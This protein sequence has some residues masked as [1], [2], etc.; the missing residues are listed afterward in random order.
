[1]TLKLW[2]MTAAAGLFAST[3]MADP[4]GHWDGHMMWGGGY[5]VFGGLMMLVFW[6]VVIA[7]IVLAVHWL[8]DSRPGG[9][10]SS[11]A[12]DILR[13]RLAKGEIDEDEFR[14]RKA[15]LEE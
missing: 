15:T 10:R 3:A 8:R 6:G 5:G 13:A 14:R 12:L 9:A 1:M 7:L 2:S 11:D 4:E